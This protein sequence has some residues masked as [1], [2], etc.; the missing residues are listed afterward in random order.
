[1]QGTGTQE[2]STRAEVESTTRAEVES[3]TRTEV[4]SPTRTEV[5]S[6]TRTEVESP[7]ITEVGSSTTTEIKESET[8]KLSDLLNANKGIP[9]NIR[10]WTDALDK[11]EKN[12]DLVTPSVRNYTAFFK[13][14]M[15]RRDYLTQASKISNLSIMEPLKYAAI[16]KILMQG[17]LEKDIGL[18]ESDDGGDTPQGN[19]DIFPYMEGNNQMT[20]IFKQTVDPNDGKKLINQLHSTDASTFINQT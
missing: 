13:T 1:M 19:V 9:T 16:P 15:V 10:E 7:T 18:K 20:G 2:S 4:E 6:P 5:E 12:N 14:F 17:L 8:Y 3:P 11:F